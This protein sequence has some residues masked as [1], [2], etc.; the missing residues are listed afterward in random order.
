MSYF[1]L[2]I[3]IS[4]QIKG[5]AVQSAAEST[6]NHL[7]CYVYKPSEQIDSERA[8]TKSQK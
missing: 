4:E 8:V 2:L 7:S 1:P 5:Q 3:H 6:R